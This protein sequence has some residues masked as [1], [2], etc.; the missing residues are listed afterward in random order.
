M[1]HSIL[2]SPH[3]RRSMWYIQDMYHTHVLQKS[4]D[5]K[6]LQFF[7]LKI[8]SL[9]FVISN[10]S[11]LMSALFKP[12]PAKLQD[13]LIAALLLRPVTHG[14]EIQA[15]CEPNQCCPHNT[16]ASSSQRPQ[17]STKAAERTVLRK[18]RNDSLPH[19]W[20]RMYQ[21]TLQVNPHL[22]ASA[23]ENCHLVTEDL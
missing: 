4:H 21:D 20:S 18:C 15:L 2:C 9:N 8:L 13:E 17:D 16:E 19:T 12:A 22:Y 23:Q 11:A 3:S 1:K 10:E 7:R 14:R 6:N 5:N